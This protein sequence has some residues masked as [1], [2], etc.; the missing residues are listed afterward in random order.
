MMGVGPSYFLPYNTEKTA[1]A[2]HENNVMFY[3]TMLT[4][5]YVVSCLP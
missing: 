5:V 4:A 2:E 3:A 1:K